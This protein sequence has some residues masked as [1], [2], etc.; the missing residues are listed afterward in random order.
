MKILKKVLLVLAAVLVLVVV[1]SFFLPEQVH[2][3]RSKVVSGPPEAAF[4]QVNT[5]KNWSNWSPWHRLDPKNTTWAFS[6]KPGGEGAW[7]SWKSPN[8]DVGNGKL[9]ITKSVPNENVEGKLDFEGMSSS[10]VGYA[11]KPEGSGTR[12]TYSMD[13]DMS[14]PFVVGK[15]VGLFMDQLIGP[16]FEKGLASLDSTVAHPTPAVVTVK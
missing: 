10:K 12:V 9:T 5:L 13:S 3:E 2:V 7:Y 1:V 15:Y 11:F 16:F 6:G 8:A 4:E 14:Q